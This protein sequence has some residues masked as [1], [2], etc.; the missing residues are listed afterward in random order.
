MSNETPNDLDESPE[1]LAIRRVRDSLREIDDALGAAE[2]VLAGA[3]A[4]SREGI[5][6]AT[7]LTLG[8]LG[9]V[10]HEVRHELL[11]L[12]ALYPY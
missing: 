7:V 10:A 11:E 2:S 6:R 8:E 1:V 3:P 5:V 9:D 4:I 12:H